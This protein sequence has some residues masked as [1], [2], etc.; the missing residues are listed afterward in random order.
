MSVH[1]TRET[2]ALDRAIRL[3]GGAG[4]LRAAF[5]GDVLAL[6]ALPDHRPG[7]PVLGQVKRGE[8]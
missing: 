6:L 8:T 5:P 1:G 2:G 7:D 3:L 4:L